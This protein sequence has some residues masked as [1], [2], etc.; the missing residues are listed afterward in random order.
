VTVRERGV[1]RTISQPSDLRG[2]DSRFALCGGP[3]HRWG[4]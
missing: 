4:L 2:K 3:A 1:K